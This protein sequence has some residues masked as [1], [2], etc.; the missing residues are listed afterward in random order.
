MA[1]IPVPFTGEKINTDD[2]DSAAWS[3][4]LLI[5]GFGVFNL[6]SSVGDTLAQK[7]TNTVAQYSGYDLS[8]GQ[9]TG[10]DVV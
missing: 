9:S 3:V 1:K 7:A 8:S 4:I 10:G 6:A 2:R 5:A